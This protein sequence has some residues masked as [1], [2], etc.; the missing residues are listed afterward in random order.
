MPL[1]DYQS[2]SAFWTAVHTLGIPY[3]RI[4]NRLIKFHR[5]ALEDWL[6]R[7]AVGKHT[8]PI[9]SDTVAIKDGGVH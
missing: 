6:R 9:V 2:K 8:A 1:L 3:I 5:P 4:N 7:R